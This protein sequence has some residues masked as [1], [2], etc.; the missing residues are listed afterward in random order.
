MK[1]IS[2]L[3]LYVIFSL[4]TLLIFTVVSIILTFKTG[5]TMDTLTT[6]FFAV[7]GGEVLMC[8]LIKIFKL[9][10]DNNNDQ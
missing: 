4:T 2:K 3:A 5:Y 7:F 10:G 6:C 9:K 1:K 8:A